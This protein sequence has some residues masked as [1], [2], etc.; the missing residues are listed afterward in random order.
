[1]ANQRPLFRFKANTGVNRAFKSILETSKDG[2]GSRFLRSD[3]PPELEINLLEDQAIR[4][5]F[6]N[7]PATVPEEPDPKA[8]LALDGLLSTREP[9]Q[10]NDRDVSTRSIPLQRPP[11]QSRSRPV[12]N[13]RAANPMPQSRGSRWVPPTIGI[14]P[15]FS[16]GKPS[17]T[18]RLL[19]NRAWHANAISSCSPPSD[20]KTSATIGLGPCSIRRSRPRNRP[21][22]GS[23]ARICST[24]I[25]SLSGRVSKFDQ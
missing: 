2:R 15:Y 20:S 13:I 16:H 3:A 12:S 25:L 1:M 17:L 7:K 18:V 8:V 4:R 22:S 6:E 19:A 10:T 23:S 24:S 5:D 21:I 11:P 9:P 14:R